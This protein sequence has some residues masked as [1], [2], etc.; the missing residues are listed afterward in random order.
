M[1]EKGS[2]SPP[3]F[4]FFKRLVH[5]TFCQLAIGDEKIIDYTSDMLTRFVRTD[6]LYKL[7]DPAG[8]RL[9]S[10]VDMLMEANRCWELQSEYFSPF[11]EKEIYRHIGDYTLFMTGIFREYVVR[12]SVMRFYMQEGSRA[13]L[14]VGEFERLLNK[15]ESRIFETLSKN[16]EFYAGALYFMK[17]L[18]FRSDTSWEPYQDVVK[19]LSEW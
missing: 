12:R 5:Q 11:R 1:K 15:P 4:R 10:V 6:N 14:S 3:L 16:F 2:L 8:R 13:Y 9:E 17:Q 18:Y 19:R 7:K